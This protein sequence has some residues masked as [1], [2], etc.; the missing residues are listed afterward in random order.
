MRG[1]ARK[2]VTVVLLLLVLGGCAFLLLRGLRR[3]AETGE[4]PSLKRELVELLSDN[5]LTRRVRDWFAVEPEYEKA[6]SGESVAVCGFAVG[7]HTNTTAP[8]ALGTRKIALAFLGS[9]DYT[10]SNRCCPL[11]RNADAPDES[12]PGCFVGFRC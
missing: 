8:L 7:R 3:S 6:P 11:S 9:C 10:K 12:K 1:T 4:V 2:I 5:A